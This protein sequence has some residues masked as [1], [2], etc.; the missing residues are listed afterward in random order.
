MPMVGIIM[1]WQS[2]LCSMPY[3]YIEI[4]LSDL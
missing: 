1:I 2:L 4:R 3:S